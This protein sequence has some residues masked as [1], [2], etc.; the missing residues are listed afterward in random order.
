MELA[1]PSI[2][3][4]FA[5]CVSRGAEQIV[6]LPYFL[7]PGK[8]WTTDIP[9]LTAAAAQS[10]PDI[11]FIVAA[12]LGLDPLILDLLAVRL[13]AAVPQLSAHL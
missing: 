6:V 4:A 8:H 7:G 13:L 1:E 12:P 10:Y 9:Q 2:A 5:R 11:P 3:T